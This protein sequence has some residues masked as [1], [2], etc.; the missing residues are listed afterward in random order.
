MYESPAYTHIHLQHIIKPIGNVALQQQPLRAII[1]EAGENV[2]SRC[3]EC[4]FRLGGLALHIPSSLVGVLCRW[5]D[6][7]SGN[8]G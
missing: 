5:K 6:G 4:P 2:V 8:V 3:F 7:D 1:L